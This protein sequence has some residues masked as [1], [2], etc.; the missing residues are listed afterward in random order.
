MRIDNE[1]KL[2]F[3][4]VLIVPKRSRETSRSNV[5][6]TRKH[7]FMNSGVTCEAIPIIGANMDSCG[8]FKMGAALAGMGVM[9]AIHKYY[10][11]EQLVD[12][13][14]N[15]RNAQYCFYTLG[16]QTADLDK[17]YAVKKSV[18]AIKYVCIDVSNGYSQ[19]FVKFVGEFRRKNPN[20]VI[21]AGNVATPEMVS[22][23]LISGGADIIKI[24]I[25]P[26]SVCLTRV[27]T[28]V[29]VPQ[30]SAVIECADAAHGIGGHVCADGGCKTPGDV[31]KAF[32]AGADFVMLGGMLSGHDECEGKWSE[33]DGEKTFQFYGMSSKTAIDRYNG[34]LK[35]YR[36]AEGKSVEI[37]AKGPVK[38]TMEQI[39][40]G[41]RGCCSMVGAGKLKD[42]PKCCT[43]CRVSRTHN[44][45]YGG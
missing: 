8:T 44:T 10:S 11:V 5:L 32:G 9:T 40:G 27:M 4:D 23:L 13:F 35:G 3:D 34:G 33:K 16:T 41:L 7:V 42:L 6:L 15:D 1:V 20:V 22:E 36:A 38:G 2:D 45:V 39:L 14:K 28:G 12:F 18:E 19:N 17:Y 29:G 43:F 26:G 31:A 24:G 25:G 37:P 21:L 30:L